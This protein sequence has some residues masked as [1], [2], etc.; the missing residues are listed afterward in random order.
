[1]THNDV[2]P[3]LD[4]SI[5]PALRVLVNGTRPDRLRWLRRGLLAAGRGL[6]A[7]TVPFAAGL[8]LLV[9]TVVALG[10]LVLGVGVF[11]VPP[12]VLAV[13]GLAADQRRLAGAW[14]GVQIREP[15]RPA[16]EATSY[17]MGAAWQRCRW[18][19]GDQATWRDL[20]WLLTGP[21]GLLLG[22]L[23]AAAVLHGLE[24]VL[25][26][27]VL[28]PVVGDEDY[29]LGWV[30]PGPVGLMVPLAVL[31]GAALVL[32][33][34]AFGPALLHWR[35]RW[36][37]VLLAPTRQAALA[38]RVE[39]LSRTRAE[40]TDA[41]AAELRRIERDLHDGAQVRLVALGMSLGMA[42]EMMLRDPVTAQGLLTEARHS[43]DQALADLRDLV[44][45]IHPPVLAERGLAGALRALALDLPFPVE[46]DI[47][48]P[49][50]PPA[51]VETA[52]YFAV[53]EALANVARHSG[54][55][56]AAVR[57]R[58][59]EGTLRLTVTDDGAGGA[60]PAAGTGLRGVQRRLAAHDGTL[61]VTSP[62]GGPTVL[63]ME[64]P[65]GWSSPRTM[66]CSGTA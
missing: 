11:L 59:A 25:L 42:E 54:A 5:S 53:A 16:P 7:A 14:F 17:G 26:V 15:Y 27:P 63:T 19:L 50:G 44:H 45:G 46:V 28:T 39:Q 8:V 61:V 55:S 10:T 34:L 3:D 40:A 33:G 4:A 21:V 66:P 36:Q 24:G 1:M 9:L 57:V 65:C 48:P 13:R 2:V 23:P 56:R 62:R 32:L 51:P 52:A 38:R 22:L 41:Q 58:H 47:E 12:V 37:R 20:L 31:L 29:L 35:A 60:D 18:L 49:G 43:S 30:L 64:V 6:V